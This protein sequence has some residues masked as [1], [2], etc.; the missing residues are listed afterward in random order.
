M[1]ETFAQ[2]DSGKKTLMMRQDCVF[3]CVYCCP[4]IANHISLLYFMY[5]NDGASSGNGEGKLGGLEC[6]STKTKHIHEDI[7]SLENP[8]IVLENTCIVETLQLVLQDMMNYKIC[9]QTCSY[10]LVQIKPWRSMKFL[11]FYECK[12]WRLCTN[13]SPSFKF[14]KIQ[15]LQQLYESWKFVVNKIFPKICHEP[16][17]IWLNKPCR[18]VD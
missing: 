4:F 6:S 2:P 7:G 8:H 9:I 18:N 10:I 3:S 12:T 13:L 14:F 5:A 15:S 16:K 11:N 17:V 1:I